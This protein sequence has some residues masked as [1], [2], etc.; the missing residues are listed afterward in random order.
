MKIGSLGGECSTWGKGRP[1]TE[2]ACG[3]TAESEGLLLTYAFPCNLPCRWHDLAV[4][5]AERAAVSSRRGFTASLRG[6]DAYSGRPERAPKK[7]LFFDAAVVAVF[8]Q[9]ALRV[10]ADIIVRLVV[11]RTAVTL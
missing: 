10:V 6:A 3:S 5:P 11:V 9:L 1:R 8:Q 4:D 7:P 2:A